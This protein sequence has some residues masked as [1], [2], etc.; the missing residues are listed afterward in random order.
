[1]STNSTIGY[2]KNGKVKEIR[3][4]SDGYFSWNGVMFLAMVENSPLLL[5]KIVDTIDLSNDYLGSFGFHISNYQGYG[6]SGNQIEDLCKLDYEVSHSKPEN[7]LK[8]IK[9]FPFGF[10]TSHHYVDKKQISF[11]GSFN[12]NSHRERNEYNPSGKL[13]NDIEKYEYSYYYNFDTN[14]V[15]M[16][17]YSDETTNNNGELIIPMDNF[18]FNEL[19]WKLD[20]ESSDLKTA[21]ENYNDFKLI[22]DNLDYKELFKNFNKLVFNSII[23][24]NESQDYNKIE[25]EYKELLKKIDNIETFEK[26]KQIEEVLKNKR[27][28][29]KKKKTIEVEIEKLIKLIS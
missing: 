7:Y 22:Y 19:S 14:E 6:E 5:K 10:K 16:Y 24:L 27:I 18:D 2:I 20:P 1:M 8:I 23:I 9:D 12:I 15:Y 29:I 3:C 4:H 11:L 13:F 28:G 21:F 26:L 25:E 17:L